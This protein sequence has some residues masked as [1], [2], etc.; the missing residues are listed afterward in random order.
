MRR[1]LLVGASPFIFPTRSASGHL[2]EVKSFCLRVSKRSGIE[3]SIHDLRRTFVTIA[4]S[5]D[6]P[7]YTLK[8]LLNHR[9]S[10]DVTGGYI[11]IDVERLRTPTER[12]CERL[13]KITSEEQLGSTKEVPAA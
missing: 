9:S 3:F 12:I 13:L 4:E 11:I 8:R 10:N 6:I 2:E 5:L 1:K 7:A